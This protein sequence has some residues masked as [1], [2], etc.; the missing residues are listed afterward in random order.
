MTTRRVKF[1]TCEARHEMPEPMPA[2]FPNTV[3]P[4]DVGALDAIVHETL[5]ERSI[6]AVDL[7]VTGLTVCVGAVIAYC[8]RHYI[9]LTLYHFDRA[10]GGYYPQ[11]VL[12]EAQVGFLNAVARDAGTWLD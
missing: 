12:D 5:K 8:V 2:L 11:I 10:T 1:T 6:G 9:P 3:D 7:Y 4:T